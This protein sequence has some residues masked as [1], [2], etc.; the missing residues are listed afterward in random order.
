[1]K[2]GDM[3]CCNMQPRASGYDPAS[4]KL[5][6]MK[7][8]LEGEIGILIE[9]KPSKH[10]SSSYAGGWVVMFSHLD[11][12]IHYLAEPALEVINATNG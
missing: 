8:T 11:Y 5:L 9:F 10:V 6:P 12:Y 7:H 1:M 2:I 4:N 3:V